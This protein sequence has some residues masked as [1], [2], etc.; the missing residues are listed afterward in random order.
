MSAIRA[1][2]DSSLTWRQPVIEWQRILGW[3]NWG[4]NAY[5]L[6]RPALQPAYAKI[7]G[8]Q[9]SR[10]QLYLNR[11]IIHHFQWLA[12]TIDASDGIHIQAEE[13]G[14]SDADLIIYMD[15]SLICLGFFAP[16][17]HIG[18]CSSIPAQTQL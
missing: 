7:A 1:F 10:V 16:M 4:L 12:D 17:L 9:I 6:L 2:I 3:I 11:A 13:W 18:F 8:K 14:K 15:V 5:P